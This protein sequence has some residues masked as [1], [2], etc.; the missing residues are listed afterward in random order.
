M[1]ANCGGGKPAQSAKFKVKHSSYKK[2]NNWLSNRMTYLLI[3]M[4][5]PSPIPSQI[6]HTLFEMYNFTRI[7]VFHYLQV[8]AIWIT[9]ITL[10]S[11]QS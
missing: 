1:C 4:L 2:R 6:P 10:N 9:L 7:N 8:A 3:I 5:V 11:D